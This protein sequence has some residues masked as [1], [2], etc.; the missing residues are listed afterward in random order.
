MPKTITCP[1]GWTASGDTDDDLVAKVQVHAK[2]T[3][4]Q[5]PSREEILAMAKP[6]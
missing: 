5:N 2:D 3:H 4:D 1:C 6:A